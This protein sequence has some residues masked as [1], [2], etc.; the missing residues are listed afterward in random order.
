MDQIERQILDGIESDG[1]IPRRRV[2]SWI[3]SA[4]KVETDALLYEFTREHWNRIKPRLEM[5]EAC[6]LIERYLLGCIRENPS[7]GRA[8]GRYE[9]SGELERWFDHLAGTEDGREILPGVV[10]AVTT[11]FLASDDD[12]RR[13]I[14]HG[15]LE[16]VLEQAAMRPLFAHWANDERLQ[17]AW[18]NALAWGDAHPNFVKQL[19]AVLRDVSEPE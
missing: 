3:K 15:F 10:D 19:R 6:A 16:H 18:R 8:L 1:P 17:E 9:A 14:E 5:G 12:V 4:T 13:A 11:L 7:G 2:R